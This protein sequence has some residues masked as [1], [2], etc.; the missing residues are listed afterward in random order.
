MVTTPPLTPLCVSEVLDIKVALLVSRL[1]GVRPKPGNDRVFTI[2][3]DATTP[4]PGAPEA[5][6]TTTGPVMDDPSGFFAT[7]TLIPSRALAGS[8]GKS[9]CQPLASTTYPALYNE[10]SPGSI[11]SGSGGA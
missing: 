5:K 7:G 2:P 1:A 8:M 6:R 9:P 10:P 3:V 11:A 4:L